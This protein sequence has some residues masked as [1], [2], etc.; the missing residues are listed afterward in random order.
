M[1]RFGVGAVSPLW[2][3]G[4]WS[5]PFRALGD[6]EWQAVALVPDAATDI[7]RGTAHGQ[8]LGDAGR[9]KSSLLRALAREATTLGAGSVYE[10]LPDGMT[11]Y[12]S[13]VPTGAWFCLDEAQRLAPPERERLLT[14]AKAKCLRLLLASHEN[15]APLFARA[16]LPLQTLDLAD[17]GA[18]HFAAV[19]ENRLAHFARPDTPYAT[20]SPDALAFLRE[21]FGSDLRGAERFLYEHF[22]AHVVSPIVLTAN[23]FLTEAQSSP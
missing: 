16:D 22:A 12:T 13:K 11:A 23:N 14:M 4:F 2:G 1:S 10:Y 7:L 9:G 15:L 17:L 19:I 5:N 18:A 20:L 8:I 3:A 21:R 6:A